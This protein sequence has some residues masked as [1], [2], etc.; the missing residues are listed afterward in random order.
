MDRIGENGKRLSGGNKVRKNRAVAYALCGS[1]REVDALFDSLTEM[2][3]S[4]RRED[5]FWGVLIDHTPSSLFRTF[6]D[7]EIEERV[8][9]RFERICAEYGECGFFAILRGR[10]YCG[11]GEF[12]C[13]GGIYGAIKLLAGGL[14]DGCT[15]K[16]STDDTVVCSNRIFVWDAGGSYCFPLLPCDITRSSFTEGTVA[17]YSGE[18]SVTSIKKRFLKGIEGDSS[19]NYRVIGWISF[20]ITRS[21]E[22]GTYRFYNPKKRFF[23]SA[24]K[25][26]EGD[27][28]EKA[29]HY[30]KNRFLRDTE[31]YSAAVGGGDIDRLAALLFV[32]VALGDTG[33]ADAEL[34]QR[35]FWEI[36]G[37]IARLFD[38]E[39]RGSFGFL[40]LALLVAGCYC[41]SMAGYGEKFRFIAS[42]MRRYSEY[43][44]LEF[45]FG[46]RELT[47]PFLPCEMLTFRVGGDGK[48]T[49][50]GGFT[51]P[52]R[53]S[54]QF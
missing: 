9:C 44:R 43:L 46:E 40:R 8:R 31:E 34:L 6:G 20:P 30:A 42:S 27:I 26:S 53:I 11:N 52:K 17:L 15:L 21:D 36:N 32:Y 35:M 10:R 45:E 50:F 7:Y 49:F 41:D 48:R 3:L 2:M 5:Y 33:E 23:R 25:I 12:R 54:R 18:E 39:C 1:E 51:A 22:V 38:G 14:G 4:E 16:L 47:A 29:F 28:G 13:E 37:E 24:I 19:G